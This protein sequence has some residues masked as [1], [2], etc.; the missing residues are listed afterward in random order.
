VLLT[1]LKISSYGSS[2]LR[3]YLNKLIFIIVY[4][5]ISTQLYAQDK[6][7]DCEPTKDQTQYLK[8]NSVKNTFAFKLKILEDKSI[9]IVNG[10]ELSFWYIDDQSTNNGIPYKRYRNAVRTGIDF[11]PRNNLALVV[12][13]ATTVINGGICR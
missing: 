12:E 7:L 2:F 13:N 9:L 1:R 10:K 5:L 8:E 11:Y 3:C 4:F 6:I